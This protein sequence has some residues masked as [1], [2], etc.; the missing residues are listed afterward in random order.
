[1]ATATKIPLRTLQRLE[2]GVWTDLPPQ[3][4]VRGFVR[5]YARHVGFPVDEACRRFDSVIARLNEIQNYE[6]TEPVGEAA[7]EVHGRRRFGL[8]LF[9]III[10]I[11]ATITLSLI[12][13]R[14]AAADYQASRP[15]QTEQPAA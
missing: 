11:I 13:G 10:L 1:V 7:A 2:D 12:W 4:F 15:G 5:S 14:G 9:L 3:V 6:N 8:A